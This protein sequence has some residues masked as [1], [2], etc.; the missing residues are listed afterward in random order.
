[1]I[2]LLVLREEG[3]LHGLLDLWQ[4]SVADEAF[5]RTLGEA[6]V[7]RGHL[8]IADLVAIKAGRLALSTCIGRGGR[9]SV[10]GLSQSGASD[11]CGSR[12]GRGREDGAAGHGHG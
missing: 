12:N 10:L 8:D 11:G 1:V 2:D 3:L 6:V 7:D 9:G 4:L 5:D